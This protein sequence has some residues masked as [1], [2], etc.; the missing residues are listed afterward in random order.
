[1]LR[2]LSNVLANTAVY[3]FRVNIYTL[4]VTAMFAETLANSQH[5]RGS[6]PKAEVLHC[7]Q[8]VYLTTDWTTGIRSP[9]EAKD[10]SSNLC[11]QITFEAHPA[12]CTMGTGVLYSGVKRV[13]GVTLTTHT[14]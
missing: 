4:V 1:M 3:I 9:A 8:S 7:C 13:R 11:V 14:N 10:F 12:S 5:R 2:E 6:S